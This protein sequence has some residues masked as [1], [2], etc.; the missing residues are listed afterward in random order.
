MRESD[1]G[2]IDLVQGKKS[3]NILKSVPIEPNLFTRLSSSLK[4]CNNSNL[5]AHRVEL[6][7]FDELPV[8]H[9]Y[10]HCGSVVAFSNL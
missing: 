6:E 9:N 2:H 7:I 10:G 4:Y 8:V 3:K 1:F 5:T